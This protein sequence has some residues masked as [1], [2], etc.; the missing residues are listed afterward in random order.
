[1]LTAQ[2][3]NV[4]NE[5]VI[6]TPSL[7]AMPDIEAEEERLWQEEFSANRDFY[8]ALTNEALDEYKQGKTLPLKGAFAK[9]TNKSWLNTVGKYPEDSPLNRMLDAG[10]KIREA[11][12]TE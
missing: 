12:N 2:N 5:S 9:K 4:P 6:E 3:A 7:L 1:M 11:E 10:A 8:M